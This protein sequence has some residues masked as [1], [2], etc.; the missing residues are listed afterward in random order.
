VTGAC[1]PDWDQY[2]V[3][4]CAYIIALRR[5]DTGP[6]K[7]VIATSAGRRLGLLAA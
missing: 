2:F 4:S 6:S 7:A 3:L 5:P 1:L